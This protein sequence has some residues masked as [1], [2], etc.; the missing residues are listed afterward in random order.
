MTRSSRSD[1]DCIG[2]WM[3]SHTASHP[4]M[5]STTSSVKSWGCGLV[6][7]IRRMPSTPFTARR[8][9]AN[10]A[11]LLDPGTVRSRPYVFTFWPRSVTSTTPRR[12]RPCTSATM[13]P[14]ARER[15]GPRT[16]GTMQKV[17]RL[18]HPTLTATQAW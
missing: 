12:A 7:R 1:P 4:A 17:H 18:S 6:N 9:S 2:K 14:S 16:R 11:F 5:A 13:S 10:R 8:S 15:W 3:C